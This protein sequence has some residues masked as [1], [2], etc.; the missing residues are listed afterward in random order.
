MKPKK[1]DT[2]PPLELSR[3]NWKIKYEDQPTIIEM[4]SNG[5]SKSEIA[6]MVGVARQTFYSYLE[7]N[8]HF[9]RRVEAAKVWEK[10][11]DIKAINTQIREGDGRLWLD[12]AKVRYEEYKPKQEIVNSTQVVTILTDIRALNK[13]SRQNSLSNARKELPMVD[14]TL[15][16]AKMHV[17]EV[18]E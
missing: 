13:D 16:D 3:K 6:K 4:M 11:Q 14:K 10:Y 5:I 2:T 7:R 17:W 8:P 18:V 12:K 9:A 15:E 1:L